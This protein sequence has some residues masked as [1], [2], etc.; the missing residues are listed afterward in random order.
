MSWD[1]I[2]YYFLVITALYFVW[3][4]YVHFILT[5]HKKNGNQPNKSD[6]VQTKAPYR[7]IPGYVLAA[8]TSRSCTAPSDSC[9]AERQLD[10]AV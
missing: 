6:Y 3:S 10:T 9:N 7:R 2:S 1:I 5:T 4:L 8:I